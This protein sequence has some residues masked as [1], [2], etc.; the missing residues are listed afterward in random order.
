MG[1][2]GIKNIKD[3]CDEK[4]FFFSLDEAKNSFSM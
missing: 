2:Y 4:G 1:F 3:K